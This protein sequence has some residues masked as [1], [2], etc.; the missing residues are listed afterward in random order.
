MKLVHVYPEGLIIRTIVDSQAQG[1]FK[2]TSRCQQI[3]I[4]ATLRGRLHKPPDERLV[5]A[6]Y[7]YVP[8]T[9]IVDDPALAARAGEAFEN[10]VQMLWSAVRPPLDAAESPR[11][12]EP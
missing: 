3:P 8:A 9:P 10:A 2:I 1:D 5:K 4:P 11:L 7:D 12:R 6:D